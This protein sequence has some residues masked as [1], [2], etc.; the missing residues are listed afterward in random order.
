[1]SLIKV[2]IVDDSAVVRQVVKQTLETDP[3][4]KVLGA[5]SDP[6]FAMEHMKREWPDVIVLDIEMPRMDGLTF[7]RLAGHA[8]PEVAAA[9]IA[10]LMLVTGVV[11]RNQFNDFFVRDMALLYWA[12][13]GLLLGFAQRRKRALDAC[14][15]EPRN[16]PRH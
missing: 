6:L 11:V 10:G 16:D 9:G 3:S 8:D 7:L 4:I 12:L 13:S 15:P 1:M 14:A 2:M 5:A